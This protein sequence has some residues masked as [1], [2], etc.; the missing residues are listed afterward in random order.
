MFVLKLPKELSSRMAHIF[1]KLDNLVE[2]G[3]SN[4]Q[5]YNVRVSSLEEVFNRIGE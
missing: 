4:M 3:L 5:S 2:N 1:A